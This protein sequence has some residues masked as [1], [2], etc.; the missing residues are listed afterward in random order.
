MRALL[1]WT[2]GV[3]R[4]DRVMAWSLRASPEDYL[5]PVS[6]DGCAAAARGAELGVRVDTSVGESVV[7]DPDAEAVYIEAH[8]RFHKLDPPQLRCAVKEGV[9]RYGHPGRNGPA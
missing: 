3:K 1:H 6:G 7:L 2:F 9:C 4:A 5:A 8:R